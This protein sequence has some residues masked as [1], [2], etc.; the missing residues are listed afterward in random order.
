MVALQIEV[1]PGVVAGE[2]MEV[3][4]EGQ[5]FN[6]IVPEGVASGMLMEVEIDI[7]SDDASQLE[8][9]ATTERI[10]VMVPD[11]CQEGAAFMVQATWGGE[12]EIV[13]PPGCGPGSTIE[14]ELPG[15]PDAASDPTEQ[16]TGAVEAAAPEPVPENDGYKFQPGQR[17]EL[18]RT[19]GSYSGGTI[20]QGWEGVFGA[21]YRVQMDSGLLKEAVP[22][23]EIDEA[24]CD[25]GDLFGDF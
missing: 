14:I 12:F 15:P 20:V 23:E 2:Q 17:V 1:P 22:E 6:V 8:P 10:Q 18:Y 5:A 21:L 3:S 19:D 13:V 4:F 7:A 24:T 11:G 25:V 16:A 9:Q